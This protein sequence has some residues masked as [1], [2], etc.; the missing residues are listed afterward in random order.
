MMQSSIH[1]TLPF[2]QSP[3]RYNYS[4][5]TSK[6]PLRITAALATS[7]LTSEDIQQN[8]NVRK[9]HAKFKQT[10]KIKHRCAVELRHIPLHILQNLIL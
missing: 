4:V 2:R 6:L 10:L 8:S 3:P 9:F 7:R 5:M 1:S